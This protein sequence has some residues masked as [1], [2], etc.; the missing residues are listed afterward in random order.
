[1][2]C[3]TKFFCVSVCVTF[4][5]LKVNEQGTISRFFKK[6]LPIERIELGS[7]TWEAIAIPYEL[8]LSFM[9]YILMIYKF[10][11]SFDVK[12]VRSVQNKLKK[13]FHNIDL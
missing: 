7:P 3:V 12:C 2:V 9:T 4:R 5:I 13:I 1:M 6:S 8:N 11:K 10:L